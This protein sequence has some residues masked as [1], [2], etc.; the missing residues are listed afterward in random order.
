MQVPDIKDKII[1]TNNKKYGSDNVMQNATIA[2]SCLQ[3]SYKVKSHILPSG[4]IIKYQGYENFAIDDLINNEKVDEDNILTKR[5]EVPKIFYTDNEGIERRYYTD[6]YI[7]S[8]QKCIEV[9]SL[10]TVQQVENNVLRKHYAVK[11]HG[12]TSEIWVY[13]RKG[14][15]IKII[16]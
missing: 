2:E 16:E 3:N 6:I 5:T 13:D 10:W 14:N 15:R 12:Y 8:Q 4:K 9:K 7:P 11:N 1:S